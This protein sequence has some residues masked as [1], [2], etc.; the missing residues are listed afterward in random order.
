[1]TR[2]NKA[3]ALRKLCEDLAGKGL[4]DVLV[5]KSSPIWVPEEQGQAY[6]ALVEKHLGVHGISSWQGFLEDYS[7]FGDEARV[8]AETL[9]EIKVQDYDFFIDPVPT[10]PLHDVPRL[11][12]DY[13]WSL[14]RT[15]CP[16][17]YVEPTIDSDGNVYP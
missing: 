11:Y 5:V 15:H 1:M 4:I 14:E 16:I 2:H 13:Q 8:I 10:I 7:D 12:T 17:A 3:A 6:N 9:R